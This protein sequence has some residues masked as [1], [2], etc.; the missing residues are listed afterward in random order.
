MARPP[1]EKERYIEA[2]H[3]MIEDGAKLEDI[4]ATRL[5]KEVGGQYGR[6]A[7]ALEELKAQKIQQSNAENVEPAPVWFN[8]VV[9]SITKSAEKMWEKISQERQKSISDITSSFN[10]RQT[11][12]DTQNK[13]DMRQIIALEEKNE[14]LEEIV[15]SQTNKIN[16]LSRENSILHEK[17]VEKND[18]ITSLKTNLEGIE[19]EKS[20]ILGDLKVANSV[21]D[22]LREQQKVNSAK[23]ENQNELIEKLKDD[24]N[25]LHHVAALADSREKSI[26]QHLADI[27]NEL[28]KVHAEKDEISREIKNVQGELF[29][30]GQEHY[31]AIS[32]VERA[33]GKLEQEYSLEKQSNHHLLEQVAEIKR[34][35]EE[36]NQENP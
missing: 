2:I 28:S 21:I 11:A 13:E 32:K 19:R 33:L 31:E 7:E 6:C 29:K 10:D 9:S 14:E 24:N 1:I 27:K 18:N 5:Q 26:N 16:E 23:I 4:R 34:R 30:K 22:Q 36:L 35:T 17:I 8:D 3:Q 12:F 15:L 25:N 20:S